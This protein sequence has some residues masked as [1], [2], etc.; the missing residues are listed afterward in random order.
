MWQLA[1]ALGLLQQLNAPP[2]APTAMAIVVERNMFAYYKVPAAQLLDAD[3][4][5]SPSSSSSKKSKLYFVLQCPPKLD[6]GI[7]KPKDMQTCSVVDQY[8]GMWRKKPQPKKK[9]QM[10]PFRIVLRPLR[11]PA[12]RRT[13]RRRKRQQQRDLEDEDEESSPLQHLAQPHI[14]QKLVKLKADHR[15]FKRGS[16]TQGYQHMFHRDESYND[17]IFYDEL[18]ADGQYHKYGKSE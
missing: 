13:Y 2:G 17:H 3:T 10:V 9:L 16:S 8:K 5:E 1:L 18:Q 14:R 12:K 4:E 6:A 7:P 11:P 15:K